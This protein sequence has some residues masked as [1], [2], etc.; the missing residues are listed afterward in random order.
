ME[1]QVSS[2]SYVKFFDTGYNKNVCEYFREQSPRIIITTL[3][4]L[5]VEWH[6]W[7][8]DGPVVVCA[9]CCCTA[10]IW[11]QEIWPHHTDNDGFALVADLSASDIQGGYR[12]FHGCTRSYLVDDFVNVSS[13]PGRRYLHSAAHM[14][15]TVAQTRTMTF[16]VHAFLVCGHLCACH[17]CT[18]GVQKY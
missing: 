6:R 9:E 18:S 15:V 5:S 7:R 14:E 10:C 11:C 4:Q 2:S 1:A 12:C 3:L 8:L 17:L 13:I 16:S